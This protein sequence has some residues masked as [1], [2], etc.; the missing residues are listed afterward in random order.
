[1]SKDKP[2]KPFSLAGMLSSCP[3]CGA[4]GD[5]ALLAEKVRTIRKAWEAAG[6]WPDTAEEKIALEKAINS[7]VEAIGKSRG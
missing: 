6:G 5:Y 4:T 7:A 3:E 2:L 1:M